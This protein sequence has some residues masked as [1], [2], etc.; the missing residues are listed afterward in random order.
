MRLRQVRKRDGRLVAFDRSKIADAIFRAAQSVGG[1]DRFLAEQLA[2]VVTSRLQLEVAE[3][4]GS[5]PTI[6]DVQDVVE[7]VLIDAGH[8]QTA[9]AYILYRRRRT[10]ARAVRVRVES[11]PVVA[12]SAPL[13]GGDVAL[14]DGVLGDGAL[15]VGGAADLA[16]WSKAQIAE[17]LVRQE[18]LTRPEAE[19]VARAV[20]ERVLR[21]EVPR[22]SRELV[23]VL[24]RAELFERGWFARAARPRRA[25]GDA[26]RVQAA[27]TEGLSDRRALD[28]A[29]VTE[30]LGERLVAQ[31][32]LDRLLA[33]AVAEAHRTGDL[34]VYDLGAP[35]RLA[36]IALATPAVAPSVLA[37]GRF[38]RAGG[39]RRA[40]AAVEE[41]LLRHAPHAGRVLALEDL[42]GWRPSTRTW[43]R[44][45]WSRR[46]AS[47]CSRRCSPRPPGG[48]ARCGSSSASPRRC[49][50]V[51]SARTYRRRRRPGAT[52]GTTP[53]RRYASRAPSCA[54]P[55]T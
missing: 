8:A 2:G 45:R 34:H 13:V 49:R 40:A 19:Q 14:D 23:D 11:E 5:V 4:G 20:E 50:R 15:G 26:V 42:N 27:L 47:S 41:L 54:R 1:E 55:R 36:A 31:H 44:T 43:T 3:G 24:V 51:F 18:G 32:V 6:E 46:S 12:A 9:K 29:A 25:E 52:T 48:G 28:P 17:G 53:T 39:A 16:R 33:P 38:T 35:L 22:V 21:A 37:G 30:G 10:E 7:R